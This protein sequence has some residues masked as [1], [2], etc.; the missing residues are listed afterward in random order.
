MSTTIAAS[1]SEYAQQYQA[2]GAKATLFHQQF[3]QLLNGGA[4][5]Y[6]SAEVANANPLQTIE[7]GL[8]NAINASA[9]ALTGRPRHPTTTNRRPF[10]GLRGGDGEQA[11]FAGHALELVSAALLELEA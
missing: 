7:Q 3:V 11:P 5:Q 2:L 10:D 1:F 6:A 8:I 4:A 9:V